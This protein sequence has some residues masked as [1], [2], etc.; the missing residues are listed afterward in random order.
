MRAEETSYSSLLGL[1]AINAE[2]KERFHRITQRA[3]A[4]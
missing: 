4:Q 3:F 1:R 2:R